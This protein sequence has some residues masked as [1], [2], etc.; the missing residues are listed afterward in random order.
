MSIGGAKP[1]R[2]PKKNHKFCLLKK[3]KLLDLQIYSPISRNKENAIVNSKYYREREHSCDVWWLQNCFVYLWIGKHLTLWWRRS[4]SYRN[5][6]I[7]L[8]YKLIDWF[9]FDRDLRHKRVKS[10]HA[11]EQIRDQ[12]KKVSLICFTGPGRVSA[13]RIDTLQFLNFEWRYENKEEELRQDHF[14]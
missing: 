7:D 8:L 12:S 5:L 4:L 10:L 1:L 14:N 3:K 2:R 6:F 9:L 13:D 11:L